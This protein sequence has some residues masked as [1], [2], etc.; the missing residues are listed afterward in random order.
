MPIDDID[1]LIKNSREENIIMLLDS[2]KRDKGMYP[3]P[4][5][6]EVI[7][8]EPIRNV[9]GVEVLDTAIPRT[10]FMTDTHNNGL[11]I[12]NG[13]IN[14]AYIEGRHFKSATS[15]FN[16]S[17]E[18]IEYRFAPQ[19]YQSADEAFL[20]FNDQMVMVMNQVDNF[21]VKYTEV[22]TLYERG[23]SS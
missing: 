21:D 13:L 16:S 4:G 15:I 12:F 2:R 10:M 8:D 9:C 22:T 19:D 3:T 17:E 18:Y 14:K 6:F 5:E 1:Y 11:R 23:K 7:F 20:A